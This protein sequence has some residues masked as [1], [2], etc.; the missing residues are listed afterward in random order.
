MKAILLVRPAKGC[1]SERQP[2]LGFPAHPWDKCKSQTVLESMAWKRKF[3][4][5]QS[6]WP[7]FPAKKALFGAC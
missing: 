1:C 6:E 3:L 7:R 2:V 5:K 4:L